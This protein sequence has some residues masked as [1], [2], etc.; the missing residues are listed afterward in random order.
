LLPQEYPFKPPNIV[1][2]TPNGRFE[3]GKK[4]CLSIS[5]HHPE[6][7]QPSWSIRTALTAL[8]G[9]FPTPG[10]GA[11]G[12]LDYPDDERQKLAVLSTSWCCSQ[13]GS[14]NANALIDPPNNDENESNDNNNN[15]SNVDVNEITISKIVAVEENVNNDLSQLALPSSNE[16]E[17]NNH[18]ENNNNNNEDDEDDDDVDDEEED[19]DEQPLITNNF[20][21]SIQ[22]SSSSPTTC[23]FT[24]TLVYFFITCILAL[25]AN[26]IRQSTIIN[27]TMN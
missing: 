26:K 13:C 9:F 19:D 14:K 7:W 22:Q 6:T 27:T 16:T 10:N 15:D 1:L 8:I 24:Q 3:V 11:I 25:L 12:A 20:S 23:S 4:I 5:A 18:N 17:N 2:L 21:N